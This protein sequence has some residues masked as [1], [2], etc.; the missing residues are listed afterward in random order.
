VHNRWY[1]D[2]KSRCI[3]SSNFIPCVLRHSKKA[4]ASD[5]F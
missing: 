4:V 5:S 3:K 2:S 1:S